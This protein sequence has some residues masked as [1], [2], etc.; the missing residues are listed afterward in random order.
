TQPMKKIMR[1]A[2]RATAGAS[3]RQ[4]LRMLAHETPAIRFWGTTGCLVSKLNS[5]AVKA[6]LNRALTDDS[7]SVRGTAAEA[8]YLA[9]ERRVAEEVMVDLLKHENPYVVLRTVNTLEH[10]R[11]FTPAINQQ[12]KKIAALEEKGRFD[13]AQRKCSYLLTLLP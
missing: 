13:Y 5:P 6:A 3:E 2:E 1:A 9:G 8:L 7:P 4:L 10:L 11:A 12:I